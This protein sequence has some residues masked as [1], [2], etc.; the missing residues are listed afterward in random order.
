MPDKTTTDDGNVP[1]PR[2]GSTT[3]DPPGKTHR[4]PARTRR[5]PVG[6]VVHLLQHYSL[7]ALLLASLVFYGTWSETSAV[8]NQAANFQNIAGSQSVLAV[9]T[10]GLL[11]PMVSG[12]LD[13]SIGST[14]GCRPSPPPASTPTRRAR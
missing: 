2:G 8:F 1:S 14:A 7:L 3:V 5:G 12:N 9:L 11:I 10:L 13:L 4:A 6:T